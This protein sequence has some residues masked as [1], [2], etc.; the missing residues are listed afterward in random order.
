MTKT[1]EL[2]PKTAKWIFI[3]NGIVQTALGLRHLSTSDSLTVW[4][5]V[6]G[7][8]LVIAGPISLIYGLILFNQTN[9]LT[10]KVQ[11]DDNG[12][13]I[14]Q[15]FYKRQRTIEWGK[16]KEITYKSFELNFHLKDNNIETVNLSTTGEIS[17]DI[18]RTIRQFA[19]ERQIKILGG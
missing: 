3:F 14:K 5:S 16:V 2:T 7:L 4:G 12:I 11:V 6:L 13:K 19:D 9:R 8:L 18:K 1:I 17:L 10:P 15:D